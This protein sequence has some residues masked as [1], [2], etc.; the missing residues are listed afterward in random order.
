MDVCVRVSEALE[1]ESQTNVS[2]HVEDG[3]LNPG[4][5]EEQPL[6]QLC[7]PKVLFGFLPK[8][9]NKTKQKQEYHLTNL[10]RQ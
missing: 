2:C 3:E 7:S 1:R 9:Q 5:L 4:P 8:K 10:F 6:S